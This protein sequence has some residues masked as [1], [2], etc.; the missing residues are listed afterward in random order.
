MHA[1][2]IIAKIGLIERH[3]PH[4][5]SVRT[6][7]VAKAIF[8]KNKNPPVSRRVLKPLLRLFMRCALLAMLAELR[9]LKTS[10]EFLLILRGMIID[11]TADRAFKLDEIIL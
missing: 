9:D 3:T 11:A 8:S 10:L 6:N 1:T 7:D 5:T 4:R 2:Q